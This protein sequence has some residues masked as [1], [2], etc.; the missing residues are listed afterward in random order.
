MLYTRSLLEHLDYKIAPLDLESFQETFTCKKWS[1]FVDKARRRGQYKGFATAPD[2]V[3]SKESP[4]CILEISRRS[5]SFRFVEATEFSLGPMT[6]V[7][8][9][10]FAF[11]K[12]VESFNV[13]FGDIK[14]PT[15][16]AAYEA[17]WQKIIEITNQEKISLKDLQEV[18]RYLVSRGFRYAHPQIEKTFF[19][20]ARKLDKTWIPQ[21]KV[22]KQE[23]GPNF[24][25]YYVLWMDDIKEGFNFCTLDDISNN[26]GE[27]RRERGEP[28]YE[29]S[30]QVMRPMKDF[31]L[32]GQ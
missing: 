2:L 16:D 14:A 20:N 15:L 7:N 25:F 5:G 17:I 32:F 27:L 9:K 24:E 10:A 6:F 8:G 30:M 21:L 4:L 22:M 28:F 19:V 26:K 3:V 31:P 29:I 11:E 1:D 13:I 23:Y 12:F 18:E